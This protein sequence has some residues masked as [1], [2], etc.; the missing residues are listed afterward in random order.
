MQLA[1][2]TSHENSTIE[3]FKSNPVEAAAY[4]TAVLDDGDPQEASLALRRI[5]EAFRGVPL[6]TDQVPPR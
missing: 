2:C 6:K 4:L 3:E 5:A 1:A